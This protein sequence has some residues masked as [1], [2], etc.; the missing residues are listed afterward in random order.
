VLDVDC[1]SLGQSPGGPAGGQVLDVDGGRRLGFEELRA[2]LRRL[3]VSPAIALTPDDFD[4]ITQARPA[5][6]LFS[7]PFKLPNLPTS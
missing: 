1:L 6:P 3:R 2:G 7:I 4:S 5:D